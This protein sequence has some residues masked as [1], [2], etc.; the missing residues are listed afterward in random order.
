MGAT[1]KVEVEATQEV[2]ETTMAVAVVL[3]AMG[4]AILVAVAAQF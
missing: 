2:V 3:E 4:E 1:A